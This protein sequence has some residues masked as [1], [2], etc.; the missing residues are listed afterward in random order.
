[1]LIII[2][3][4]QGSGKSIAAK[5]IAD[6]AP[7]GIIQIIDGCPETWEAFR[8]KKLGEVAII[9]CQT[10]AQWALDYPGVIHLA[11]APTTSK[12]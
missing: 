3:G 8:A 5:Q 7:R 6:L 1:M 12:R 11:P 10:P 4:P 2:S 9:T